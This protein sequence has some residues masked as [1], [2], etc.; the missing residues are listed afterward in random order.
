MLKLQIAAKDLWDEAT[1][2]FIAVKETKLLLEHSLISISNWESKWKKPF[3]NT[4]KTTEEII[5]YIRC[6]TITQGVDPNVYSSITSKDIQTVIE[7][8]KD[9]YTATTFSDHKKNSQSQGYINTKKKITSEEI[10]Y[11][12]I[13]SG[14]PFECE[15]WNINRLLTLIRICNIKGQPQK[16]MGKKEAAAYRTALNNSRRSKMKT[17]G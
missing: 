8:I 13:E 7:Y 10:Y 3:L 6:M 9:P 12:M 17:K 1:E 4:N 15:K 2:S 16:K 11:W 14:V 5:D